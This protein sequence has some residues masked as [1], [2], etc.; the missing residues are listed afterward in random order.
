[1]LKGF[2]TA[3]QDRLRK[4]SVLI[5]GAGGLGCPAL[6]YLAAAGVG[7]I[8]IVDF[9]VV[10]L[11]NLQRQTL[12]TVED[13]EKPKATTAAEKLSLLNPDVQS[14]VYQTRLSTANALEIIDGFDIVIDGTDN[15]ATRYMINDACVLLRKTLV[16]GS[17]LRFEGQVG[18]L[19]FIDKNGNATAGYR[20]LFPLPPSPGTIPSCSDAGVLG[21]LPGII[22][23]MQ[24]SEA[25]KMIT[26]IGKPLINTI[27]SYNALENLFYEFHIPPVKNKGVSLPKTT[28]EFKNFN[29]DWF[30]GNIR[31]HLE[32][33]PEEFEILRKNNDITVIDV[34]EFGELPF[35]NEFPH[36]Q[37]PLSEFENGIT[38]LN[39]KEK[40][41][42]FCKSGHRSLTALNILL[43]KYPHCQARNLS[44]GIETW[45][46]LHGFHKT[47]S[48]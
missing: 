36:V 45:K 12:F 10:E 34:R 25:I 15:F 20:D 13:I 43:E 37:L 9:D 30:C 33:S 32:I 16:Y 44:G 3:G 46:R 40:V 7:I 38:K 47:S 27:L 23:T 19:N 26:G 14:V 17:V 42:L 5:V 18:V 1:M 24:A 35:V 21:V 31:Q 6:Q 29:Y 2:G 28:G 11:T 39:L 4:A 41:V 22:G 8:G 48:S